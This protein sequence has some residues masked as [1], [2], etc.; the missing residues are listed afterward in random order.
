MRMKGVRGTGRA[1]LRQAEQEVRS[2]AGV[3][4]Q[5][6]LIPGGGRMLI[7]PPFEMSRQWVDQLRRYRRVCHITV[8]ESLRLEKAKRIGRVCHVEPS[9][10]RVAAVHSHVVVKLAQQWRMKNEAGCTA[11]RRWVGM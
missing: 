4:Y 1:G 5:G 8:S 10:A 2:Q 6:G 11:V 7:T 9:Y 3:N